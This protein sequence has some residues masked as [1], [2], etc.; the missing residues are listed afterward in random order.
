MLQSNT[1]LLFSFKNNLG[2]IVYKF[3]IRISQTKLMLKN[4]SIKL[5]LLGPRNVGK[6]NV[7]T[8]LSY[9][10]GISFIDTDL[11]LI[12]KHGQIPNVVSKHGWEYFRKIEFEN[13]QEILRNNHN[14]NVII[15]LGGGTIAHEYHL[16]RERNVALLN[17][18][19]PTKKILLYPYEELLKTA[20]ILYDRAKIYTGKADT[21][22]PLTD[23]SSMEEILFI[24]KQ[25]DK[26]Y[27]NFASYILY[28][29]E[30]NEVEVAEY[31]I[32]LD[33]L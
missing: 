21:K 20:A 9:L 3:Y 23:L 13:L 30:M 17:N 10:L 18:F 22:P 4:K 31:I 15:A 5:I 11:P 27:K 2:V 28:S 32:K 16:Y 7:G 25:R 14:D 19:Q 8:K 26:Y 12:R 1:Y 29:K 6:T 33:L 24:L